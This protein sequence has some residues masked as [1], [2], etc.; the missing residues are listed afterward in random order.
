MKQKWI[1]LLLLIL[2][3]TLGIAFS[4]F[5]EEFNYDHPPSDILS[6]GKI[7]HKEVH[8]QKLSERYHDDFEFWHANQI[9]SIQYVVVFDNRFFDCWV[10]SKE[11]P[12][13]NIPDLNY[14][15]CRIL[16]ELFTRMPHKD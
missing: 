9:I 4:A 8:Y 2:S 6:G 11:N 1:W 3:F 16:K 15:E 13:A 12:H 5:A 7:L 14:V 10:T